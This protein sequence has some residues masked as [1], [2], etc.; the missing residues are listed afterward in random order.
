ML[1]VS[2]LGHFAYGLKGAKKFAHGK[3][4]PL[5]ALTRVWYVGRVWNMGYVL[6]LCK[7]VV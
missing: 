7:I 2:K 3:L 4:A 5:L 6:M 1:I